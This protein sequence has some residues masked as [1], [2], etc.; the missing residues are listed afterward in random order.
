MAL[1][2]YPK[3]LEFDTSELEDINKMLH[4]TMHRNKN[5]HRLAKWWKFFQMLRRHLVKLQR[6]IQDC[7]KTQKK[8]SRVAVEERLAFLQLLMPKFYRSFG[9]VVADNQ[10]AALGAMLIGTLARVNKIITP[11]QKSVEMAAPTSSV[12]E[13]IGEPVT[14]E[15]LPSG[16]SKVIEQPESKIDKKRNKSKKVTQPLVDSGSKDESSSK[17]PKKK[18]K[19]GN[20]IDEIF[21]GIL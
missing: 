21:S 15:T 2:E 12:T 14:R 6:E 5:Q 7:V 20:A 10:Y 1:P 8:A 16:S 18:R 19:K 3:P 11:L 9:A 4:L 17:P 13:D